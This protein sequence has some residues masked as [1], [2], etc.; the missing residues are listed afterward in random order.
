MF[1]AFDHEAHRYCLYICC[2][3]GACGCLDGVAQYL[4]HLLHIFIITRAGWPDLYGT[5]WGRKVVIRD[6][7]RV[8]I[9]YK[10]KRAS[11][12]NKEVLILK[13]CNEAFGSFIY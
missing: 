10:F 1:I 8:S 9:K 7:A 3:F 13:Y 2:I 5:S 6:N 11:L 12:H 4:L